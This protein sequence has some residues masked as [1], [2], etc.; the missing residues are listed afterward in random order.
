MFSLRFCIVFGMF[1]LRFCIVFGMFS[2]RFCIVYA[3]KTDSKLTL[4]IWVVGLGDG[5]G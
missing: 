5:A 2:L 3:V 4:H 1:S